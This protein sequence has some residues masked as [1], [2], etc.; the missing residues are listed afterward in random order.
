MTKIIEK[1]A[2]D[3]CIKNKH[4][5]T[6]PRKNVLQ[7]IAYSEKPLKAYEVLNKLEKVLNSPKP[8]TIYRAIEFWQSHNFIHRIES[9]N[10][11]AA[12]KADHFHEGSQFMICNVC[13]KVIES[14]ICELPSLIKKKLEKKTFTPLKWN[15]EVNGICN[16]CA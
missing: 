1:K 5:F 6:I 12:C 7:V 2:I 8:P 16:Q 4:R 11:Y 15:L 9:L 3:F 10:A 14:H 13:G